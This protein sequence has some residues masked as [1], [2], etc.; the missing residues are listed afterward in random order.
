MKNL[1]VDGYMQKLMIIYL[2]W[3]KTSQMLITIRDSASIT[4]KQGK[5]PIYGCKRKGSL[6]EY[7]R[8]IWN[9]IKKGTRNRLNTH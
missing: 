4:L 5:S 1:K 3:K 2:Q 6:V 9:K 7:E 8:K